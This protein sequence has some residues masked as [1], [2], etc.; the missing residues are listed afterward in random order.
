MMFGRAKLI[1]V[2]DIPEWSAVL[3]AAGHELHT[4]DGLVVKKI[5]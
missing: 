4:W 5:L 2:H 1:K 3:Q